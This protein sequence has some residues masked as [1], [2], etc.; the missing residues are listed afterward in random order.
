M[1]TSEGS[2]RASLELDLANY[3][4]QVDAAITQTQRLGA[5]LKDIPDAR[6]TLKPPTE[7]V[8]K[9]KQLAEQVADALKT[10]TGGRVDLDIGQLE[11]KG[12]NVQEILT[13][14]QAGFASTAVVAAVASAA[15][16][17]AFLEIE[18]ML[19]EMGEHWEAAFR[20]V[21]VAT[22]LTGHDLEAFEQSAL[23]VAKSSAASTEAITEAMSQLQ[24]RLGVTGP[25]LESLTAVVTKFAKITG[26]DAGD[27]AKS[28]SQILTQFHIPAEQAGESLDILLRVSQQTRIPM[29]QLEEQL[30]GRLGPVLQA[31]GFSF[32]EAALF[33]ANMS[34][35]GDAGRSAIAALSKVLQEAADAGKS[36]QVVYAD[37]V[38][39]LKAAGDT[40][41]T[42]GAALAKQ[43][44]PAFGLL[45][46]LAKNGGLDVKDAAA[47]I[48]ES[49]DT[50][51]AAFDRMRSGAEK[52]GAQLTI[53]KNQFAPIGIAIAATVNQLET[54]LAGAI[55]FVT[56]QVKALQA[57]VDKL[58]R[59][60]VSS[61]VATGAATA[62]SF[63]PG[64][65]PLV[66]PVIATLGAQ[67]GQQPTEDTHA[68]EAAHG[69]E[70]AAHLE[71]DAAKVAQIATADLS[72]EITK[73]QAQLKDT[74][75]NEAQIAALLQ[76]KQTLEE[77]QK[78]I[79]SLPPALAAMA[80]AQVSAAE[81]TV[82]QAKANVTGAASY[83]DAAK[84]TAAQ[85]AASSA[86]ADEQARTAL[87]A[88]AAA[89]DQTVTQELLTRAYGQYAAVE[90]DTRS[91]EAAHAA[92]MKALTA[93]TAAHEAAVDAAAAAEQAGKEATVAQIDAA[94]KL[95]T[96]KNKLKETEDAII[97]SGAAYA[98]QQERTN[99][100]I[101]AAKPFLDAQSEAA[102]K[103]AEKQ[104]NLAQAIT[105]AGQA[106]GLTDAQIQALIA[107]LNGTQAGSDRAVAGIKALHAGTDELD[108]R[109]K[110]LTSA[111]FPA[112]TAA[113]VGQVK[114]AEAAGGAYTGLAEAAKLAGV[115]LSKYGDL[116]QLTGHQIAELKGEMDAAIKGFQGFLTDEDKSRISGVFSALA[117]GTDEVT[118]A[119]AKFL[120]GTGHQA[121]AI[122]LLASK[123]GV[124]KEQ[125]AAWAEAVKQG[126]GAA[127][128][129]GVQMQIATAVTGDLARSI[130]AAKE[131]LS[132][133]T[134]LARD[135]QN[136]T[137]RLKVDIDIDA[138]QKGIQD[139]QRDYQKASQ[140]RAET[141]VQATREFQ[142]QQ[143]GAA[144]AETKIQ[145]DYQASVLAI[146]KARDESNQ[147]F[148]RDISSAV[149]TQNDA[150]SKLDL[151]LDDAI[152]K[153]AQAYA[154]AENKVAEA[155]ANALVTYN[156]G[157]EQLGERMKGIIQQAA[158]AAANA[159]RTVSSAMQSFN[160]Q[161]RITANQASIQ[162]QNT[163]LASYG[164]TDFQSQQSALRAT[165]IQAEGTAGLA[166]VAGANQLNQTL[167]GANQTLQKATEKA[168]DEM[169][170]L[171]REI[172]KLNETYQ[173]TTTKAAETADLAE[174]N[175]A[176]A[177]DKAIR[178]INLAREQAQRTV[179]ES[180]DK[181]EEQH[182]ARTKKLNDQ[183][184]EAQQKFFDA[185]NK[186]GLE[187]ADDPERKG[188]T[189][190]EQ[191][192][193]RAEAKRFQD[194][195]EAEKKYQD[196][197]R[198]RRQ[199]LNTL[200]ALKDSITK[201]PQET[202]EAITE[203]F[204][205]APQQFFQGADLTIQETEVDFAATMT[206]RL[207]SRIRSRT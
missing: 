170:K 199:T 76:Q 54:D 118:A 158:D 19:V 146:S 67:L 149:R 86:A 175:A 185:A 203:R 43:L 71:S 38:E 64:V 131:Q 141:E 171:S 134:T 78:A 68:A 143:R 48:N 10:L 168:G 33:L 200:L 159:L 189:L 36:P 180:I 111:T 6:P 160:D 151:Q 60:V 50:V 154:D 135:P 207:A 173:K 80:L 90:A 197:L 153:G 93:A 94:N 15:V 109:L 74:H 26:Q 89:K 172:T 65:G 55:A 63:I 25:E 110:S 69:A 122:E 101:G 188:R 191:A 92:S 198:E 133:L 107:S 139:L 41:T 28:L 142:L 116:S 124:G 181:A 39:K 1:S 62:A 17:A 42:T 162:L 196:D 112:L 182:D 147:Q 205:A 52:I 85:A 186:L 58:P 4:A 156:Q 138:A 97:V 40:S 22:G 24:V 45:S 183:A 190:A 32:T 9:T 178:D 192:F 174:R 99:A 129:A 87:A 34:K 157:V 37:L 105:I 127:Q 57:Q 72:V 30:K 59:P 84:A 27:A 75:G 187:R 114:E 11:A 140:Q 148:G 91:G 21:S 56:T 46:T 20:K 201:L 79:D 7:D 35:Q 73:L 194:Q 98:V 128:L 96:A 47:R 66:A 106:M 12:A 113:Q 49:G 165:Q 108:T 121:E 123:Y 82:A 2:I 169:G 100:I 83:A 179:R 161:A 88:E 136:G 150:A 126:G 115:D 206:A 152:A 14:L 144:Q 31:L 44:G 202:A 53:L 117:A 18:H 61:A 23:N 166:Q 164:F 125:A 177:Q 193:D 77:T 8:D 5:A 51:N 13:T 130:F 167:V 70:A 120:A 155:F 3:T 176:Q 145:T 104:G 103:V 132:A 184:D 95:A 163:Q 102:I 195:V 119:Q 16:V 29:Q 81:A 137:I 204:N